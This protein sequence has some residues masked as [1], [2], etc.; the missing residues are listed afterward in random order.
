MAQADYIRLYA[1]LS[2]QSAADSSS[3]L[4]THHV[5]RCR[6]EILVECLT[7]DFRGDMEAVRHLA[8]SGLD[9][10]AHNIETVASLQVQVTCSVSNACLSTF[11]GNVLHHWVL[12]A[13]SLAV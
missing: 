6:P 2:S 1:T 10:F 3:L 13:S 9:V 12:S 11:I 5:M 7:P 8:G 4:Q